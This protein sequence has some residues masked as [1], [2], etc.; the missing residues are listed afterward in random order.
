MISTVRLA[1]LLRLPLSFALGCL[2]LSCMSQAPPSSSTSS[3]LAQTGSPDPA[4]E[5]SCGPIVTPPPAEC[6]RARWVCNG[7]GDCRCAEKT[8]APE[9]TATQSPGNDRSKQSASS[10]CIAC[11]GASVTPPEGGCALEDWFCNSSGLCRCQT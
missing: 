6:T 11:L 2:W 4:P 7:R 8:P 5:C 3:G 9:E 10:Q 1:A